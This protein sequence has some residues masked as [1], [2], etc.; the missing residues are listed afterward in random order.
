MAVRTVR[1]WAFSLFIK[2]VERGQRL[3]LRVYEISLIKA[4]YAKEDCAMYIL[5]LMKNARFNLV[6]MWSSVHARLAAAYC[7]VALVRGR[8]G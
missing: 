5:T 4:K 1:I 8:Y 2:R 3:V 7:S 6:L